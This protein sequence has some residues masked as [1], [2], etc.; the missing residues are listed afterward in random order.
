MKK[1]KNINLEEIVNSF[2]NNEKI[3][4]EEKI[5][6]KIHQN[7]EKIIH[8]TDKILNSI[9]EINDRLYDIEE[10]LDN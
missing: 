10:M 1:E 6:I 8:S 9:E 5:L 7:S 3:E 2:F 4:N